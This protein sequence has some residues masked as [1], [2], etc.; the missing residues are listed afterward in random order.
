[1]KNVDIEIYI[2][3]LIR[4]FETN[5]N[6][7]MQLIGEIQK[8]KFY[9]KLKE[10]SEENFKN[11]LDIILTREQIIDIVLNMKIPEI[12]NGVDVNK[13]IMKTKFGDIIMN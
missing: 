5:P 8:E 10:K 6:D 1:M 9:T 3:N 11:G 13:L 2:S 4:F 12:N 7:L